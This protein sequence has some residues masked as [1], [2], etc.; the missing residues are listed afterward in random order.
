MKTVLD[1]DRFGADLGKLD[2]DPSERRV[3]EYTLPL[4]L[5]HGFACSAGI[6]VPAHV[7]TTV[8]RP[9]ELATSY[10][11][12][13]ESQA[14]LGGHEELM[15]ARMPGWKADGE[16]LNAEVQRSVEAALYEA[17]G[18][19]DDLL[20]AEPKPPVVEHWERLTGYPV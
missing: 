15:E 11:K 8:D 4:A 14:A 9:A 19:A 1:A 13:R 7:L 20:A 3:D 17:Q 10:R 5:R 18:E 12:L 16:Q 2:W 6:V